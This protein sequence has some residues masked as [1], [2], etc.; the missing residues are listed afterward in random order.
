M[1]AEHF[2]VE[3]FRSLSYLQDCLLMQIRIRHNSTGS[4]LLAG[5]FKLRL[6]QNQEV[7]VLF[8][9]RD[10]G[11]STL[12]TEINETSITTIPA[13]WGSASPSSS[14]AFRSIRTTRGSCLS[15]QSKLLHAHVNAYT[16]A[17]P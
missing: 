13:F 8:R 10:G 17:A 12:L 7:G 16:R 1:H 2:E 14:R 6:D 5:Q 11:P 15:F 3:R 9:L 4:D